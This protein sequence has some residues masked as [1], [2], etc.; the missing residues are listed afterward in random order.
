[1]VTA[2]VRKDVGP[3]RQMVEEGLSQ[4]RV[5]GGLDGSPFI[6]VGSCLGEE[7]GTEK[8]HGK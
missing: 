7:E 2:A 1:M 8:T 5:R 6:E 4:K 3:G